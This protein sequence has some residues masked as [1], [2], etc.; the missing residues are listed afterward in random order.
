MFCARNVFL[1]FEK[2]DMLNIT[3]TRNNKLNYVVI[4]PN[5]VHFYVFYTLTLVV[6]T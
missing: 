3:H 6:G 5:V 1:H 4:I 2:Y